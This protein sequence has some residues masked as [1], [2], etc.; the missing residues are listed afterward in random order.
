[1]AAENNS[2]ENTDEVKTQQFQAETKQLLQL[3]IHSI[4]S[5]KEIFLREL[6]SNSSDAI[7]KLKFEAITQSELNTDD[8]Y[9]I[10]IEASKERVLTVADNGIGMSYQEVTDNIGTIARSGT[11]ELLEKLKEQKENIELIGQ[12]G[13][14]FY[15]S[16]MVADSI[17]LLT[18]KAGEET[19]TLWQSSGDGSY[20]IQSVQGEQGLASHG[21][22]ITL[23]LKE[24]NQD[25][26]LDDFA[27]TYVLKELIKKYSDFIAYPI[28]LKEEV[29]KEIKD[30]D[31][32]PVKDDKDN[33]KTETVIE[34]NTVNSMKPI[35]TRSS[36][37]VKKEEYA[38]FY[39]HIS[40][41]WQEPLRTIAFKAEGRLEYQSLLFI[42]E[43]APFDFY[44]QSYEGGLQLYVRRVMIMDNFKDVLPRYLRFVKGVVDSA[45]LPL[46]ISRELLQ[47]NAVVNQMRKALSG[48]ILKELSSL[49]EKDRDM[50][51]KFWKEFGAAIKEGV[52]S[53][54]ENKEALQNLLLFESSLSDGKL[55]TLKEY[56][57][58]MKSEQKDIYFIV[59]DSRSSAENSP[60]IEVFLEKGI[61][62][63]YLLDPVDEFVFRNMFEY[64]GKPLKAVALAKDD[65]DSGADKEKKK[66]D[67]EE[68]SKEYSDL[69][70]FLKD[71]LGEEVKE[72]KLS[73]NLGSAP[74]GISADEFG[75]SPQLEKIL[76][77]SGQ[78]Q[79]KLKRG[80]ELNPNHTII[81]KLQEKFAANKEDS[82]IKDY[83]DLLYGYALM[84]EGAELPDTA[85]YN[86]LVA[87][88]MSM[89]I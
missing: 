88:L 25:D 21:T 6:I 52:N 46:N 13:V 59:A 49:L 36:S 77:A 65:I 8:Q 86:K 62:V 83:A 26:G 12:F 60:H 9:A 63:L 76:Q 45:D 68:K 7:D 24:A 87:S 80:L 73:A 11:K 61:E 2:T 23:Q 28:L 72:V 19:S 42:P 78:G 38:E 22:K 5:H 79:E 71:Y 32:N 81:Q 56:K 31:G 43:K 55:I 54:Y 53:D 48:K 15:S 84:S 64:D 41:D 51:L 33:V 66:K 17:T 89:A 50:Y 58:R 10:R 75:M 85:K 20:T 30:N 74:A 1:M 3:M 14:G 37:D 27:D 40:H 18:R 29:Q 69:V 4:Y 57:E 34:E 39:R 35:W 67:L 16:F 44:Y 82:I 70:S 47:K